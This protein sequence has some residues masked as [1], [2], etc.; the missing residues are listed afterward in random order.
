[1]DITQ[2][3]TRTARVE[4]DT[5]F[6][7]TDDSPLY[8]RIRTLLQ[9]R[10]IDVD[11]AVAAV[12]GP[13]DQYCEFGIV[14][15]PHMQVFEFELDYRKGPVATAEFSAW[16]DLTETYQSRARRDAIVAALG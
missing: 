4:R 2:R 11:R 3:N 8:Q 9:R 13:E 14:V 16:R 5:Q 7:R 1:M 6:L 12:V 10:G 15:M